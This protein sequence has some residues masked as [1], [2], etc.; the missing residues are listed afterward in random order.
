MPHALAAVPSSLDRDYETNTIY[1]V[2]LYLS[3]IILWL[4]L[5]FLEKKKKKKY[6]GY[7][8]FY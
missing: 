2:C 6:E 8:F 5:L 7:I 1:I 3:I 4:L